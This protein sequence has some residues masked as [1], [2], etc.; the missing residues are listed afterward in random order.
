MS[1][2]KEDHDTGG[3]RI[4]DKKVLK[5]ARERV[6]EKTKKKRAEYDNRYSDNTGEE[7]KKRKLS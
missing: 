1:K 7:S 2:D 4:S 6:K 5:E 3:F